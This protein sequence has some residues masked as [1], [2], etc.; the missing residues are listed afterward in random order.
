[1]NEKHLVIVLDLDMKAKLKWGMYCLL[2]I[3]GGK[4]YLTHE[5]ETIYDYLAIYKVIEK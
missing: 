3:E 2:S 5:K 1:M 4:E